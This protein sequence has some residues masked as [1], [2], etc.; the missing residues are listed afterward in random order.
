MTGIRRIDAW[1]LTLLLLAATT[2]RGAEPQATIRVA[3]A[4]IPVTRD[5]A[6]NAETIHRALDTAI[7]EG[8]DILLTPE[9]SLSGYTP[10]FDQAEVEQR[11]AQIVERAAAADVALALGTCF[12]E[13]DDEECYNQIR[14]YNQNG[15]FLGFHSKTLLCSSLTDPP[16]GEI[17]SYA[18][19]PLRTFEI[20]GI[21]VGGLICNDMWIHRLR[22]DH[23]KIHQPGYSARGNHDRSS[24]VLGHRLLTAK[25]IEGEG[26]VL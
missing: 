3:S 11:L 24:L 8:A 16:R 10:D 13:P 9:G 14:F 12:T 21:S 18:T 2:S 15:E 4:Q 26:A 5:I 25:V 22:K 1:L 17:N 6:I 7:S 19:R 20:N 23:L